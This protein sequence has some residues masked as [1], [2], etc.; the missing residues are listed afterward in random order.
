[1]SAK[2]LDNHNRWRNRTV[3]FRVS[4]EENTQIDTAVKL[5]GLTKQDYITRRLLCK[6][7]VVQGNPR[8][9]KALRNQMTD[10]LDELRRIE[11]GAGVDDE[12]LDKTEE[13]DGFVFGSPCS[14]RKERHLLLADA[15]LF[16][17]FCCLERST[18]RN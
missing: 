17:C 14:T 16:W 8:V 3:A 2:N 11:A 6:D 1:M 15:F 10:I 9:F 12:L 4:E 7:V 18:L 13:G 5:T